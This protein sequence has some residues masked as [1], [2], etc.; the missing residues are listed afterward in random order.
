MKNKTGERVAEALE[1]VL[2]D[3]G[4]FSLQTD[5][6][7]EFYN[8][9][10]RNLLRGRGVKHFSSENE[11]IKASLVERFNRTLRARLHRSMTARGS[12][13]ILH[14]L[15]NIVKAYTHRTTEL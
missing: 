3:G 8:D 7:K 9:A 11:T 4:I 5:N 14:V 2:D 13:R 12:E 1:R 6:G 10:V 15:P